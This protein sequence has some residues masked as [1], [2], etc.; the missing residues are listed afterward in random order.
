MFDIFKTYTQKGNIVIKLGNVVRDAVTGFEGV[1]TAKVEYINGCTQ[2]CVTPK[3]TD[4]KMPDAVYLDHQRLEFVSNGIALP[5]S[6]TGGEMRDAP[7]TS[8][9]G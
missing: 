4:G 7:S 2:Y 6:D 3:S 8:Y 9:R 1:A 5:S